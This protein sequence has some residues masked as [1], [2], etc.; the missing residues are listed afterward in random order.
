MNDL[1]ANEGGMVSK[2]AD[3]RNDGV[4]VD[5]VESCR[6][7]QQDIDRWKVGQSIGR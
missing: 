4:F 1:D 2:S 3:D 6:R 7:L 5:S